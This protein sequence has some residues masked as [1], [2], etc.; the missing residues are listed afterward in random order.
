VTYGAVIGACCRVGDA[1]SAEI[2]FAEMMSQD[3]YPRPR[4]PAF[5]TMM[6][7]Y[8]QI[9]PNRE[10]MLSFYHHMLRAGVAPTEHTYKVCPFFAPSPTPS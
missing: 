5:N 6:Q 8:V 10:K 7:L 2:L 1:H 4:V 9:H 3:L